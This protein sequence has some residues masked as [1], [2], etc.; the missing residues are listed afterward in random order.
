MMAA[1]SLGVGRHSG[2]LHKVHDTTPY[3]VMSARIG[4][5][6]VSE[7]GW[8]GWLPRLRSSSRSPSV[9]VAIGRHNVMGWDVIGRHHQGRHLA[10][11]PFSHMPESNA[12]QGKQSS[13]VQ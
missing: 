10:F 6:E 13:P 7:S 9:V 3:A 12:V 8:M 4:A 1:S 2:G 11:P 5:A